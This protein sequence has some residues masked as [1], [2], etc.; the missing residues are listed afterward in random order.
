VKQTLA[1]IFPTDSTASTDS[2]A[3]ERCAPSGNMLLRCFTTPIHGLRCELD[4]VLAPPSLPISPRTAPQRRLGALAT[5]QYEIS[6]LALL[7]ALCCS[8]SHAQQFAFFRVEGLPAVSG[9]AGVQSTG[10]LT[11]PALSADG[12]TLVLR[13]SSSNLAGGASGVQVLAYTLNSGII[14]LVSVAPNGQPSAAGTTNDRPAV[15]ADGRYVAFETTSST[16]SAGVAGVHI[17]RVDRQTQAFKLVNLT[18][19]GTLPTA[20]LSKLGGISGDGRFVV[21]TSNAANLVP[22]EPANNS[23]SVY[24]RDL[25]NDSTQRMDVSTSGIAGNG[26]SFSETPTISLDGRFVAFASTA[27]NLVSGSFSGSQ[28]IYVRDRV[29]NITTRVS[30]GPGGSDLSGA[31]NASISADGANIVFRSNTLGGSATQLWARRLSTPN[32]TAVP[33]AANMGLCDVARIADTGFAITQCR[34]TNTSLPRQAFAWLLGSATTAPELISGSDPANT[35]P[36]NGTSGDN[37]AVSADSQVFAFDSVASDL[38]AIDTNGVSD[39]FV[40]AEVSVLDTLFADG[41]E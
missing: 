37:V 40:Y 14:S 29:A 41:F 33:A 3:V 30:I 18:A 27:T 22:G 36:G 15:S 31:G 6:G 9:G 7:L 39:I 11:Q 21:F 8:V 23:N 38:V 4:V 1:R 28:R 24:L 13:A 34:S 17:V 26:G 32:A 25:L 20:T 12:H 35:I 10:A 19:G 16:Y 2:L 5:N